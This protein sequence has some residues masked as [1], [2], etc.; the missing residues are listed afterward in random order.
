LTLGLSRSGKYST[1]MTISQV[2]IADPLC[3]SS[4]L[5]NVT[6]VSVHPVG[7]DLCPGTSTGPPYCT[8]ASLLDT[9]E[10]LGMTKRVTLAT[11]VS[12][13]SDISSR[14]VALLEAPSPD[15]GMPLLVSRS[16]HLLF[17]LDKFASMPS[18][19]SDTG[20]WSKLLSLTWCPVLQSAPHT[21]LK[22]LTCYSWRKHMTFP[23]LRY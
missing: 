23:R 6:G 11:L 12:A 16:K 1:P 8:D 7:I 20:L 19:A 9:L 21:G 14:Y 4:F 3:L 22:S 2:I 5:S 15:E 18:Y 13:A 17:L 10:V